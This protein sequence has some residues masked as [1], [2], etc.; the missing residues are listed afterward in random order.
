MKKSIAI[1]LALVLL[2]AAALPA[3]AK[4]RE[5]VNAYL[6]GETSLAQIGSLKISTGG[7]AK[8]LVLKW[9]A[10]PRANGYEV[11]R[12]TT[13]KS[14]SYKKIDEVY[15]TS[16]TDKGL[17]HSTAYY[18]AVRAF[19]W[20]GEKTIY[21]P[22]K[23]A[24]LSTRITKSYASARF[25][26][27]F[28]AMHKFKNAI[29]AGD[30]EAIQADMEGWYGYYF[31]FRLKGVTTKADAVKYLSKYLEKKL[32][33]GIVDFYMKTIKGRLYLWLPEDPCE[34]E[35]LVIND[36][37]T[38]GITYNEKKVKCKFGTWFVGFEEEMNYY[39]VKLPMVYEGGRWVFGD[40][41]YWYGFTFPYTTV[42][43]PNDGK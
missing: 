22:L 31:P 23:K 39:T 38:I 20:N 14:G 21:S 28:K 30:P 8:Q 29:K 3:F 32:A 4:T 33:Q 18:Y 41:G 27:V 7:K 19:A 13:G 16:C 26:E 35:A 36:I 43:T 12:S 37:P 42:I 11:L 5:D 17:K 24:N 15:G 34:W 10:V 1:L 40:D 6:A 2:F 9:S 25:A